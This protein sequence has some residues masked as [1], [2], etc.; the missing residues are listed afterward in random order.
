[1]TL[2]LLVLLLPVLG[3]CRYAMESRFGHLIRTRLYQDVG[4]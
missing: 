2:L 4:V 3:L 1:M